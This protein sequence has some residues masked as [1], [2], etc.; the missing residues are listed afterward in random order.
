MFL[1]ILELLKP[2]TFNYYFYLM[3]TSLAVAG[4][5]LLAMCVWIIIPMI[6]FS[7]LLY[8]YSGYIEE[9][10]RDLP[11][12]FMTL[13]LILIGMTLSNKNQV[14]HTFITVVYCLYTLLMSMVFISIFISILSIGYND[15]KSEN[16]QDEEPF[17]AELSDHLL[18]TIANFLRSLIPK[19]KPKLV[20]GK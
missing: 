11:N 3:R 4:R 10:F 20:K 12:S 8:L 5:D 18:V 2:L 13:L 16:Q 19:R 7:I 15:V 9:S 6:A 17:D 1:V 14:N